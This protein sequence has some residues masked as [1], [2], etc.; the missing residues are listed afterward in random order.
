MA[1][2]ALKL[3]LHRQ[4]VGARIAGVADD[5]ASVATRD[6]K[7]L[8]VLLAQGVARPDEQ[9][10]AIVAAKTEPD[11]VELVAVYPGVGRRRRI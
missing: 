6:L 5:Q 7:L 9:I 4:P 3:H 1:L 8:D 10:E 11:I 2:M